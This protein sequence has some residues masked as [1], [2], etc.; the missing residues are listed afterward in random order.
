MSDNRKLINDLVVVMYVEN[1]ETNEAVFY[2][3]F[4]FNAE[5]VLPFLEEFF[6]VGY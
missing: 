4:D 3:L 5:R 6:N 1:Q 2:P